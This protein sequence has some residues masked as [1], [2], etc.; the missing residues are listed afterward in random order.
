MVFKT[1]ISPFGKMSFQKILF[2]IF[3]APFF[4]NRSRNYFLCPLLRYSIEKLFLCCSWKWIFLVENTFSLYKEIVRMSHTPEI[5]VIV[6]QGWEVIIRWNIVC[7]VTQGW[8]WITNT[9]NVIHYK[10]HLWYISFIVL[11]ISFMTVIAYRVR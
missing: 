9:C 2:Q 1:K 7:R 4:G 8:D 3:A 10:I 6:S 11:L 5:T